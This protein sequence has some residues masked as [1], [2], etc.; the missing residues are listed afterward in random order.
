MPFWRLYYHIVWA[1]YKRE[2]LIT[3]EIERDLYGY[4]IGKSVSQEAIVHAVNGIQDHVHV[5]VSIP[6]KVAVATFVGLLKGSSSHH[7][8]HE[9][10]ASGNFGWQDEYGVASFGEGYLARAVEY[11]QRQKEHH[12]AGDL[13]DVFERI[14]N[15]DGKPSG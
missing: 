4:L 9:P 6:P 7:I 8:N 14:D 13:W 15:P 3:P 5:V 12:R 10:G 1:T 2:P 11:V